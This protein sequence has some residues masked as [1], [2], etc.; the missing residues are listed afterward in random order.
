LGIQVSGQLEE[1]QGLQGLLPL[2]VDTGQADEVLGDEVALPPVPIPFAPKLFGLL[3]F[4]SAFQV[5]DAGLIE[6]KGQAVGVE[7][8]GRLEEGDGLVISV[9]EDQ[10]LGDA[11]KV[12]KRQVLL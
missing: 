3:L 6:A 11:N 10:P 12:L 9:L 7:P 5:P 2:G 4:V 8:E 1:L